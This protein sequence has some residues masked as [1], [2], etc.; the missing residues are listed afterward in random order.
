MS[1]L[2]ECPWC[3][4]TPAP[5]TEVGST[6]RWRRVVGCCTP[7]PE[8][9]HNPDLTY[10]QNHDAA[11][12]AWNTRPAP[13]EA[14][15]EAAARLAEKWRGEVAHPQTDPDIKRRVERMSDELAAALGF[16]EAPKS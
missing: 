7:G 6:H 1:E 12:T 15:V 10:Q 13:S 8:I 14:E 9:R 5:E 3:G 16:C 4:E 11:I 2:R